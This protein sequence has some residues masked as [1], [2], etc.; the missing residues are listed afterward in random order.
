MG[1]NGD[2]KKCPRRGSN[3]GPPDNKS[4]RLTYFAP[5]LVFQSA[6]TNKKTRNITGGK[7]LHGNILR[8]F[9]SKFARW[10]TVALARTNRG[11]FTANAIL[12]RYEYYK[13][14]NAKTL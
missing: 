4:K 5:R 10:P 2:F 8:V 1:G 11:N 3:G 12:M 13:N 7:S 6:V 9:R 14:C